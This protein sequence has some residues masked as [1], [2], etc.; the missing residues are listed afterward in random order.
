MNDGYTHNVHSFPGAPL[1]AGR[2]L[3]RREYALVYR[4]GLL[5]KTGP[6]KVTLRNKLY[7]FAHLLTTAGNSEE[8]FRQSSPSSATV[9]LR[10]S[11][12]KGPRL[13]QVVV[14]RRLT[15][16]VRADLR[17]RDK[18]AHGQL[19]ERVILVRDTY[20]RFRMMDS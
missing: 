5:N 3:L 8:I 19:A 2:S 18:A 7:N 15:A 10:S 11:A 14:P 6:I 9:G 1:Q 17:N 16:A 20:E 4:A 13:S 12:P